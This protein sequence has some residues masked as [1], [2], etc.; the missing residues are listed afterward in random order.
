MSGSA[1]PPAPAGAKAVPF[2]GVV[3]QKQNR[4]SGYF[5]GTNAS[6]R[7]SIDAP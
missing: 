3:L 2:E 4:G 6:G 7:V 5:L 1:T